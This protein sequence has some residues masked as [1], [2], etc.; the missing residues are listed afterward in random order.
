MRTHVTVW[1]GGVL[2]S[3]ITLSARAD[4]AVPRQLPSVFNAI[5][6]TH[7]TLDEA[8]RTAEQTIGGTLV[9]AELDQTTSP[10]C[11]RVD[12]ADANSRTVTALK[13][14]TDTG[15]VLSTKTYH[16]VNPSTGLNRSKLKTTE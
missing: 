2:L 12:I 14:D 10:D 5:A 6:K 13:I 16:P 7:V 11:Y 1:M 15:K 9:K 4:S 8:I 3:L